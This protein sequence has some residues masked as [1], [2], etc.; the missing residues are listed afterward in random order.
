MNLRRELWATVAIVLA[1]ALA[2]SGCSGLSSAP[3]KNAQLP[4]EQRVGDL[5]SRMTQ[6][7][8]LDL[9]SG[10]GWMESRANARL[11]IPDIRMADGPMGIRAWTG[12]SAETNSANAPVKVNSTA[13]PAGI[14]LAATWNPDLAALQGKV[15]AQEAKS[16]GRDQMLGPTVNINRTPFWG[17]NFEGYGEDPYLASRMVVGYIKGMQGEGIIATVKHFAANN[18]EF[19]RRTVNVKA[20]ER[21]LQ[22]IYLPTFKAAVQEA[23][24]WSVMSAYNKVN[25]EWCPDN[26]HL[27]N[28]ILKHDWG[29][30]GYVVSDWLSTHS[31]PAPANGGLDLEMPGGP[32]IPLWISTARNRAGGDR[33]TDGGHFARDKLA[34]AL[35]AGQVKQDAI[36]DKVRRLLRV[37]FANGLFERQPHLANGPID[38]PEQMAAARQVAVQSIVLLKNNANLLPLDTGKLKSIAV[39][40]PD[41]TVARTGG[42][43]S[44]SVRFR[45]AVT[46]LD[47]IRERAGAGIRVGQALGV[48]MEGEESDKETPQARAA[49]LA[50]AVDLA[51]KSDVALLFVGDGP[52]IESEGFD[53]KSLA[54]PAGQEELIQAVAKANRNTVVVLNAGAPVLMNK[55]LGQVPAL[56]NAWFPGQ[57]GGH[58]IA[59]VLFG[60]ANP[61][62]KLP[63]TFLKEE[64][65]SPAYGHYPGENSEVEYAEG[66]YVGYRHFDKHNIQPLFPFGFGLSYTKFA[67]SDLKVSPAKAGADQSVE[68]SLKLANTGP[69]AGAEV[70]QLYVRDVKSSLDRPVKELKAFERVELKPGEARTIAF[71]LDKSALSYF[72]P[73]KKA[74]VAEPGAFEVQVGASSRDIRL[75]GTF[76]LAQ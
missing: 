31:T 65:D 30:K 8:K 67:Y 3:Y 15:I 76:E 66:I 50:E 13:F 44:S 28:D 61:S 53:R 27:L 51:R 40:G 7:E 70:V 68:V 34:A 24:V 54:L 32:N 59:D 43:G 6:Y 57:E 45:Y 47:G 37:M 36:D 75:K 14:A 42:G 72:D 52:K 2:L 18:Q 20:D 9:V 11:G 22:E 29:F 5:M 38:T 64:K 49:L 63:V 12:S 41:A 74:W 35:A 60:D 71:K 56:V 58:A 69:R 4:V 62:G 1:A 39:I 33:D 26:S 25:G 16:L 21:T 23:G 19:K 73:A 10:A 46:P 48:S 55:W 17:R